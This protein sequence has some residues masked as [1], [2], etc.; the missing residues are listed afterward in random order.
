MLKLKNTKGI[1]ISLLL[2][3]LISGYVLAFG[4]G[5]AYHSNNPLEISAG[6]S[7]EVI[8]N[9]QNMPGPEDLTVKPSIEKGSE[10][11]ELIDTGN[12]IVP[13]GGSVD[14]KAI[15]RIPSNAQIGDTYPIRITFTTVEETEPGVFGFGSSVGKSFNAIIVPTQEE[16]ASLTQTS[17]GAP[18][19][20]Y[21]IIGIMVLAGIIIAIFLKRRRQ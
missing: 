5:C 2:V 3:I 13:V 15:I 8:F 18:L 17:E 12:I 10:I 4:V 1:G 6:E 7:K 19:W 14:V 9:L 20:I 11:A 21:L 16:K